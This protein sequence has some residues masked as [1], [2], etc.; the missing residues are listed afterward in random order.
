MSP[1]AENARFPAPVMTMQPIASSASIRFTASCNS[2]DSCRFTALS[3]SG[4]L[5]VTIPTPSS[6]STRIC[7]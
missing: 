3:L 7:S 2:L 1:P 4:R 6:A 5:S